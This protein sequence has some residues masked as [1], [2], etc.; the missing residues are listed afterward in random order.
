MSLLKISY[1]LSILG[2]TQGYKAL[3]FLVMQVIA[4]L[5][6]FHHLHSLQVRE[7]FLIESRLQ[8]QNTVMRDNV[9]RAFE[10]GDI[11]SEKLRESIL[12]K[13]PDFKG[14]DLSTYLEGSIS[15]TV[16]MIS[17]Y[18]LYDES[19]SIASTSFEGGS[20]TVNVADR[21]YFLTLKKGADVTYYGPYFSR[22]SQRWSYTIVHRIFDPDNTFKGAFTATMD[23][24]YL[25][26]FCKELASTEGI[27][28]YILNP[29]NVI[30]VHCNYG[31][32]VP[33]FVGKHLIDTLKNSDID[34]IK[35]EPLSNKYETANWVYFTSIIPHAS[36]L[37]V[38]TVAPKVAAYQALS[39]LMTQN[40]VMFTYIILAELVCFLM[41][42]N[43]LIS[44][45]DRR[46]ITRNS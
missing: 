26:D 40:Y 12:K 14:S 27:P 34:S 45:I 22:L 23:L 13:F 9:L 5:L 15:K 37:R 44:C 2:E 30:V 41:Y 8:T 11:A 38:I 24:A 16:P 36:E 46:K 29:D 43:A 1:R 31:K 4:S 42:C 18:S 17:T 3:L 21:P 6:I 33:D 32:S 19:G 7:Q 28:T 10:V 25:G 20:S 39:N 35:L